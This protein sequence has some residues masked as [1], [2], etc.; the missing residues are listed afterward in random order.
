MLCLSRERLIALA[1]VFVGSLYSLAQTIS[2]ARL[3]WDVTLGGPYTDRARCIRQTPD[4]GYIVACDL[5]SEITISNYH[6]WDAWLLRLDGRGKVIWK[7]NFGG[8]SN[9]LFWV[10]QPTIDGG[11]IVGGQSYSPASENKM[12]PAYG[13]GDYWLVR[14]DKS[15]NKLWDKSFGGDRRDYITGIQETSDGGFMVVGTSESNTNGNKTVP[16]FATYNPRLADIWLLRLHANGEIIWQRAYGG[17]SFDRSA[18]IERTASGNYVICG[19]SESA[20]S[21]IK[22]SLNYGLSDVWV[23]CINADGDVLWERS[24]GG[25]YHDQGIHAVQTSDGG[26]LV[27]ATTSS[28]T[29]GNK[30]SSHFGSSDLWVIKLDAAGTKV[31]ERSFGGNAYDSLCGVLQTSEGNL[32][33]GGWAEGL[34][35]GG[36]K[37]APRRSFMGD[38]W[39]IRLDNDGNRLW[40]ETYSALEGAVAY[41]I[42]PTSD[43]GVALAGSAGKAQHP[44][45]WDVCVFKI[46]PDS[47]T[48]PELRLLSQSASDV[49]SNVRRLQLAGRVGKSYVTEWTHDLHTWTPFSTNALS[50]GVSEIIDQ[51]PNSIIRYYRARLAE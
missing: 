11:W 20:P 31:W 16:L 5:F 48:A 13:Q 46:G 29:S 32:I 22:T 37:I 30:S 25:N 47:L 33:V 42:V 3:Q 2:P 27:G 17:D 36:N 19:E 49:T 15:G 41:W 44:D 1:A 12:S 38:V 9:E 18:S 26:F 6:D 50:S 21:G 45:S 10:V 14:L 39:L 7:K 35:E 8:T 51:A 23:V 43:G 28:A 24:F 34:S 40:E 4:G